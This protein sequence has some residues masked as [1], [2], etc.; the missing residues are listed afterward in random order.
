MPREPVLVPRP[1]ATIVLIRDAGG[2]MEVLMLQRNFESGFVPGTHVFP[3]GTLDEEDYSAG[4]QARCDGPDDA[5]A[6]RLLGLERGGLAYWIAAIRE[7]FEE[8]GVVMARGAGGDL[9]ETTEEQASA[10]WLAYRARAEEGATT[11][12]A[13]VAEEGVRLATGTLRYF[14]RWI[15]PEG[16]VRRYDTRFFAAVAPPRQ[17]VHHD[18]REAIAHEWARPADALERHAR[19]ELKLRTPTQRTLEQFAAFGTTRA[20]L[21]ALGEPREIPAVLPRLARDGQ[22][23]LPGEAGYEEAG[24]TEGRGGWRP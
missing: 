9:V 17:T 10:R 23:L 8:A 3:G 2:G 1:A 24:S 21:A 20:L 19:G 5:A 15:T 18:N 11:F 12:G 14:S 4:L 13:I 7:L 22:V 16:M 6:S